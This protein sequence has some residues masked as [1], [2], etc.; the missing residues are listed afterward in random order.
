MGPIVASIHYESRVSIPRARGGRKINESSSSLAVERLRANK[1]NTRCS[2]CIYLR[3]DG[4]IGPSRA[5][6][7][8]FSAGAVGAARL[9]KLRISRDWTPAAR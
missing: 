2:I 8:K 6:R 4:R 9:L 1:C 7:E 5:L 3:N